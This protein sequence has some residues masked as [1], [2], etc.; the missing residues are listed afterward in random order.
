MTGNQQEKNCKNH[1]HMEMKQHATKKK[2]GKQKRTKKKQQP[3]DHWR[4]QRRKQPMDHWR[5]QRRNLKYQ[6]A[7]DNKVTIIQKL[8][9]AAEAVQEGSL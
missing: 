5:N 3:M 9:D 7:N 4:N 1:K 8:W 6:E 2:K